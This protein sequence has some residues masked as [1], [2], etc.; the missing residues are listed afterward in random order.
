MLKAPGHA[1]H[2]SAIADAV[3]EAIFVHTHRDPAVTVPSRASLVASFH[4]QFT[5][6]LDPHALG[7]A[8][9]DDARHLLRGSRAGREALPEERLIDVDYTELVANP[10]GV[11]A[12]IHARAGLEFGADFRRRLAQTPASPA[13]PRHVYAAAD[14]GLSEAQIHAELAVERGGQGPLSR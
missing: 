5:D 8:C 11:V 4:G 13:R 9:L 7:H 3:P 2:L 14:F 1:E 6:H 10:A 12:Q